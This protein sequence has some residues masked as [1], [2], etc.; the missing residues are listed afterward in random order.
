MIFWITS[1]ALALMVTVSLVLVLLRRSPDRGEGHDLQVYRDQMRDIERDLTRG[2]INAEDAEKVRVEVSRRIL[3]ADSEAREAPGEQAS[4]SVVGWV[5]AVALGL[6]LVA[7]SVGLYAQMGAPGYGDMGLQ[8]R[9]AL[10]EKARDERPDQQ[11]FEASMPAQPALDLDADYRA[12]VTQLRE[13]VASRPDDLAGQQ[14]MALHEARSGDFI[15][16]HQAQARVIALMG[17][18]VGA[19]QFAEYGE[20]LIV[21]AG[22]YVSPQAEDALRAALELDPANGPSR[23]YWGLML[24]QT[25]R[26]DLAFRVW[27]GTLRQG[28]E[29]AH[30]LEP[31][32]AGIEEM[33]WRAG[34]RYTL[35]TAPM[36]PT[37]AAP[38]AGPSAEDMEMAAEMTPEQQQAMI[39]GMV[40]R[41]AGR[42]AEQGGSP[43]E[44]AQLI[45]A[46][47]TLGEKDRAQAIYDEAKTVFASN[48]VALGEV[49]VAA[50]I[51]GL[52]L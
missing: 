46:L 8:Q 10:A 41:L 42:L 32:R 13:T 27:E 18:T 29:D 19:Q 1:I 43:G 20:L 28:P 35:P 36:S 22:G 34:V 40:N 17:D 6:V 52:E 51:A 50:R 14:L 24:G 7:G 16:A 21:A 31:I 5:M 48:S 37:L 44:W 49:S 11:A 2:V 4:S 30:W 15:A 45:T 3:V 9:I 39:R 25:G 38:L 26:P 23:Y 12:L 47:G 33:A